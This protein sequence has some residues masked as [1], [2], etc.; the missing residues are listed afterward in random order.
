MQPGTRLWADMFSYGFH[1]SVK[2]RARSE[3]GDLRGPISGFMA[4]WD[5]TL[6]TMYTSPA[7]SSNSLPLE[8]EQAFVRHGE[9]VSSS[10][11]SEA[12]IPVNRTPPS[13]VRAPLH[14]TLM[15]RSHTLS[16]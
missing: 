13:P 3:N 16:P 2:S 10:P 15:G 9:A 1:Q 11:I 8:D 5:S 4:S 12:A 6:E 14:S 7:D